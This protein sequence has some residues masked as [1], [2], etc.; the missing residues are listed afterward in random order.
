MKASLHAMQ[1]ALKDADGLKRT[2]FT[3]KDESHDLIEK[4]VQQNEVLREQNQKNQATVEN[5]KNDQQKRQLEYQH[6][7]DSFES[8]IEKF[9]QDITELQT[10][11]AKL[12]NDVDKLEVKTDLN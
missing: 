2:V 8:Q 12:N 7:S 9:E 3:Q 5:I 11:N 10:Q 1:S 6:K 4:L